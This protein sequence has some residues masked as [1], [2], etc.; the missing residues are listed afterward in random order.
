MERFSVKLVLKEKC[1]SQCEPVV[2]C[3]RIDGWKT[4]FFFF[5]HFKADSTLTRTSLSQSLFQ[6]GIENWK[7][8]LG[9]GALWNQ[10]FFGS[11]QCL[12]RVLWLALLVKTSSGLGNTVVKPKQFW[13]QSPQFGKHGISR[14][15]FF[16]PFGPIVVVSN[17][18]KQNKKIPGTSEPPKNLLET[19][20]TSVVPLCLNAICTLQG[21]NRSNFVPS[22]WASQLDPIKL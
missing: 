16:C 19:K 2:Y 12:E 18:R 14:S 3:V 7:I 1:Q 21:L 8:H 10:S 5:F 15:L 22:Q 20:V 9:V 13:S 4:F 6:Y 11:L 17:N